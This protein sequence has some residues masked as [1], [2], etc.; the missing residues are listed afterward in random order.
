MNR[1]FHQQTI[2]RQCTIQIHRNDE[3][4][5]C[6]GSRTA[7]FICTHSAEMYTMRELLVTSVIFILI[8]VKPTTS[9][10]AVFPCQSRSKQHLVPWWGEGATGS[11]MRP[12]DVRYRARRM[13]LCHTATWPASGLFTHEH[14]QVC[15]SN[16]GPPFFLCP[17]PVSL[18]ISITFCGCYTTSGDIFWLMQNGCAVAW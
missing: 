4:S 8:T 3:I 7:N 13:L 12:W 1:V 5:L 6:F 11:A 18:S 15:L 9:V 10:S 16:C 2:H 14:F 17:H